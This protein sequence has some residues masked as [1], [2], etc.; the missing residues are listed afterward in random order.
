MISDNLGI[1]GQIASGPGNHQTTRMGDR[2]S[3]GWVASSTSQ[4]ATERPAA[5]P[6]VIEQGTLLYAPGKRSKERMN[7]MIAGSTRGVSIALSATCARTR[8][9]SAI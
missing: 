1:A 2:F 4:A 3:A 8:S 7:G 9:A 6:A 5:S